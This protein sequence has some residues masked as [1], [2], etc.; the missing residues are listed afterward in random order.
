MKKGRKKKRTAAGCD[1]NS[2]WLLLANVKRL[3]HE[4]WKVEKIRAIFVGPFETEIRTKQKEENKK[5][6]TNGKR[7]E[8]TERR[9]SDYCCKTVI[10]RDLRLL[11]CLMSDLHSLLFERIFPLIR[12]EKSIFQ[13]ES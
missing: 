11:C 8:K 13:I 7:T 9:D 12:Y 10:Y 2:M 4:Q 6:K 3:E 1:A 5:T